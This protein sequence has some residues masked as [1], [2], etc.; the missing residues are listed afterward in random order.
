MDV[1]LQSLKLPAR[2][3]DT[4]LDTWTQIEKRLGAVRRKVSTPL[5][6]Y[7]GKRRGERE[8]GP[9]RAGGRHRIERVGNRDHASER[10]NGMAG[11]PV[12]I[13]GAVPA[14]S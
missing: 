9:V 14:R 10:R 4:R 13:A 3:R 1:L 8:C 11:K 12:R 6:R 7:F 2:L 5:V